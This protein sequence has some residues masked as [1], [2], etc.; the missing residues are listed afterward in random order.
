MNQL[1]IVGRLVE[2]PVNHNNEL[3]TFSINV[4]RPYKNANGEYETDIIKCLITSDM[5]EQMS[6]YCSKGDLV[7]IKGHL[8]T[9]DNST[10]VYAEK[11]TFLA[12]HS[13]EE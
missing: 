13:T 5:Q 6:T 12:T 4:Q 11:I 10:Y 2:S 1:V 7:G 3:F 9:R 8:E